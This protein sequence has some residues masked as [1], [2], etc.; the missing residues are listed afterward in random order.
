MDR[1]TSAWRFEDVTF[2]SEKKGWMVNMDGQVFHSQD[3]GESWS[4]QANLTRGLRSVD[5][6]NPEVGIIGSISDA[7]I[8]RT[9]DSG[10]TWKAVDMGGDFFR[11]VCGISHS[12][13]TFFAAGRFSSGSWFYKSTDEGRSWTRKNLGH[14]AH[15][16]VDVLFLNEKEGYITGRGAIEGQG[17]VI[18]KT[19]DGG[20]NWKVHYASQDPLD[21][22]VWKLEKIS[23]NMWVGSIWSN[24]HESPAYM[25]RS[26]DGGKTWTKHLVSPKYFYVEGIGFYDSKLGWM[27]GSEG[28]WET[29]DGGETW[30][31]ISVN[32]NVNRFLRNGKKLFVA[33]RELMIYEE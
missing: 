30:S 17:A 29:R 19:E 14:L 26:L 21:H 31:H 25:I 3:G 1:G 16:L 12:G 6:L 20:E 32:S 24:S 9:E 11:G 4:L 22:H 8:Y 18:L 27:G 7:P 28:L 13:K 5:F 10:K 15:S 2:A 33:G 23:E